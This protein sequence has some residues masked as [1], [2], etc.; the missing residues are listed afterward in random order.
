MTVADGNADT[1]RADSNAD[2][3]CTRRHRNGYR[4]YRDGSH[5]KT[6]DHRMLL[7]E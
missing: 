6:L 2:F 7:F 3:F 1:H 4:G 5:Y